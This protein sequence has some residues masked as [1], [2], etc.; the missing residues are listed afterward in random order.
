MNKEKAQRVQRF[1]QLF[2]KR[3]EGLQQ[4]AIGFFSLNK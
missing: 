2:I 3:E 1:H 4:E